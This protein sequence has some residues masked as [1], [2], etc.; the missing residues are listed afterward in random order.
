MRTSDLES[1]LRAGECFH[2]FRLLPAAWVVL[3]L[4]GHGFTRFTKARFR[5][6]FDETFHEY[7]IETARSL[8]DRFHGLYA[9]TESD[10]ISILLPREWDKFDRELEKALSL[11]AALASAVFTRACGEVVQFDSRVWVGAR[12]EDVI[13]YFRWRQGDA[14]RCSLNGWC[15]WTLRSA[16]Q[17][18]SEATRAIHGRSASSKHELL[19]Q[20]GVNFNDL[21]LWQRRGTGL[22]WEQ[23]EKEGFDPIR[24]VA[25]HTSRRRMKVDRELP[26]KADY[27]VLLARL[28][29]VERRR[30]PRKSA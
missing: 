16:G 20:H 2:E 4:D 14:A 21:P 25:V 6:P 3:R 28:M 8:L 1:R 26:I 7:M 11:S 30:S 24:R 17:S 12:D 29:S 19:F 18:V 22:Y 10:E 23:F 9:Y 5:K 27:D 13:D 15:Y